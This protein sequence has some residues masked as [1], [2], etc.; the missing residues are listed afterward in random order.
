M[1][2]SEVCSEKGELGRHRRAVR[3]EAEPGLGRLSQNSV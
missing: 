1:S 2:C 3:E